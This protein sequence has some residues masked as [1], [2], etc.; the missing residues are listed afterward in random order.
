MHASQ[1]P[2]NLGVLVNNAHG[3]LDTVTDG[4]VKLWAAGQRVDTVAQ[5]C[6]YAEIQCG[7]Y[8][9][10]LGKESGSIDEKNLSL[11]LP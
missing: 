4:I 7:D 5:Y 8:L 6:K 9:E 3:Y 10:A 1:S 11:L 2:P